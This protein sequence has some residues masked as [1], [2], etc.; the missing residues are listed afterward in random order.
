M[1]GDTILGD[2]KEDYA[3][4]IQYFLKDKQ[5]VRYNYV[6]HIT[7]YYRGSGGMV[8]NRTY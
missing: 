7:T 1:K 3:R 6:S 8:D 4:T 2:E 5:I